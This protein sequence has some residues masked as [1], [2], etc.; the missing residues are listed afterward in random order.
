MLARAPISPTPLLPEDAFTPAELLGLPLHLPCGALL[1]NRIG[2][3]SLS[4]QLA[5]PHNR[6]T[7]ELL[8]LYER[9]AAGGAGLL[10]TGN[11]MIDRTALEEPRNVVVDDDRDMPL[12]KQWAQIATQNGVQCWVQVSHPGRQSLRTL[13][14][15]PV[16]PSPVAMKFGRGLYATPRALTEPEIW[17]IIARFAR[18]CSLIKTA[19]FSGVQLQGG[20]GYLISSFLSPLTNQRE[21]DWGGTP[22]KRMR[23]LF[24]IYAAVRAAV[25]P[26]FPIGIK[27]NSADFQLG[28]FGEEESIEV[29][30]RLQAVGIDL[31]E[32]SGGSYESA[33][34][35][36]IQ[37]QKRAST[38]AREAYFMEY[39]QK[40]RE[41][42]RV[43][44]M[45]TG[46]FRT[47]EGMAEAV[48]SDAVDMVGLGRPLC[49]EPDLPLRLLRGE[50]ASLAITPKRVGM[51]ELDTLLEV[52]WYTQQLGRIA[53]GRAP[54]PARSS[55]WTLLCVA[56]ASVVDTLR[57]QRG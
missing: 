48:G 54:D 43:P 45:L 16:A 24:E 8:R 2:K 13:S 29:V 12:L 40:V 26:R 33:V 42:C 18:T 37:E 11:V 17:D 4:E 36:G 44:L 34:M 52:F 38:L 35:M 55:W 20:H 7:P 57:L 9:W 15:V 25:G 32:V 50:P 31:I 39:A 41:V 47:L 3:A 10:I 19:G 51:R 1:P 46:G 30:K 22:E 5:D 21:D 28:G 49:L 14:P 6:P 53:K 27:L 56:W 23:F